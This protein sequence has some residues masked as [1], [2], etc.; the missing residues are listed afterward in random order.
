MQKYR[1][2]VILTLLMLTMLMSIEHFTFAQSDTVSSK[3]QNASNALDQAFSAVLDAE[4]AGANVTDLLTQLNVA[5]NSLAQAE[6]SYR[7]G[8]LASAIYHADNV[9]PVTSYIL[10]AAQTAEQNAL[11]SGQA[12]IWATIAFTVMC[13]SVFLLILFLVWSVFNRRYIANL[14]HA[15][16]EVTTQ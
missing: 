8:D 7:T 16:P 12:S 6:N 15:K 9:L 13:A 2:L 1:K 14:S 4:K 3:I 10:E 5:A 11:T